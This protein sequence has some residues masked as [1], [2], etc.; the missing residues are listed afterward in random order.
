MFYVENKDGNVP[1]ASHSDTNI[2]INIFNATI[3]LPT[4][5]IVTGKKLHS[6]LVMTL[7]V[8]SL[9]S[10]IYSDMINI[11]TSDFRHANFAYFGYLFLV[12][13]LKTLRENLK[14]YV[15]NKS[16]QAQYNDSMQS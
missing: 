6:T 15:P 16:T 14:V 8:V 12:F 1:D 3:Y 5:V 2:V 11:L 13:I 9:H 7:K 10:K 4:L